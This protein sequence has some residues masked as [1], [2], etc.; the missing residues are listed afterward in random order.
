MWPGTR[1]ADFD[2]LY[3]LFGYRR[4]QGL[5]Y[6]VVRGAQKIVLYA[7]RG[8]NGEIECTHG[9]RQLADGTWSSKCGKQPLIRHL[10][11]EALNG[12]SYGQPIA[13]YMRQARS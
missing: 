13:V 5:D 1:V 10:T 6:R 2:K 3:G 8:K 11:P 7:K 12:E 9:A 4:V